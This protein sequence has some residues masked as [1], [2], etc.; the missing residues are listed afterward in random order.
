MIGSIQVRYANVT[1]PKSNLKR[2]PRA[3]RIYEINRLFYPCLRLCHYPCRPCCPMLRLYK[4]VASSQILPG[5]TQSPAR[6]HRV[7]AP[8]YGC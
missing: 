3:S 1:G 7:P 6:R 8:G 2:D 4:A 5:L